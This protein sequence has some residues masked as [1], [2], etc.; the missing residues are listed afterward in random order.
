MA[1]KGH[2]KL[3]DEIG[4]KGDPAARLVKR[5]VHSRFADGHW[6]ER[7]RFS[8]QERSLTIFVNQRELVTILCTPEKLNY[9]VL[10]FLYFQGIIEGV[11]DV[12]SIRVC[13]DEPLVEVR[14]V[15]DDFQLP[16]GR[17]L[18]SG[19]GSG[20][21]LDDRSHLTPLRSGLMVRPEQITTLMKETMRAGELYR[22][23]GGVHISALADGE[24]LLLAAEDI[25]RH[26]TLDKIQ[27]ESLYRGMAT[28]DKL[29]LST[30]RLSSEMVEKGAKM[31]TPI[32]ASR[33]SPT[34]RAIELAESLGITLVGYV[35]GEHLSIY[36][37]PWRVIG[38]DEVGARRS[39]GERDVG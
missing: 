6:E 39:E 7:E 9:L 24:A 30:G 35:R 10:G 2:I 16:Q 37:Q 11:E 1:G 20:V 28:R 18:T 27:G 26:N 17:L 19:C 21:T 23:H 36:S 14:L 33:N 29:L 8:A 4:N 32:L 13:P 3:M 25:G 22:L 38:L 12:A 31:G 15:K 34:E 5:L